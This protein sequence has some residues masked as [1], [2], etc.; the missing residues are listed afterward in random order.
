MDFVEEV[1][2]LGQVLQYF[3]RGHDLELRRAKRQRASISFYSRNPLILGRYSRSYVDSCDI[4][5]ASRNPEEL[6]CAATD[7]QKPPRAGNLEETSEPIHG[8]AMLSERI[9]HCHDGS[10][11]R[12]LWE[13]CI[14][15]REGLFGRSRVHEETRTI[16][17]EDE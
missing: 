4:E 15:F 3:E 10:A 13:C 8:L 11:S 5:V 6:T 1:L 2:G 12:E 16:G 14:H 17:T 7:V 9:G